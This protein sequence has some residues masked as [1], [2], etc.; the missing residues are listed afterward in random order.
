[1]V[2][3]RSRTT[4]PAP[5]KTR[6]TAAKAAPKRK[7]AP[8]KAAPRKSSGQPSQLPRLVAGIGCTLLGVFLAL[9]LWIGI[10]GSFVGA[11]LKDGSH[12]AFGA[13]AIFLPI[14]LVGCGYLILQKNVSK[15]MRRRIAGVPLILLALLLA[16]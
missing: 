10:D 9:L 1:M 4:K 8:R 11:S 15:P 5:K 13:F 3:T 2:A 14:I 16:L 12:V 7:A 6:A